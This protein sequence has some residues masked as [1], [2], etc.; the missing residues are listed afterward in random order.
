[1]RPLTNV[2]PPKCSLIRQWIFE[3]SA[4]KEDTLSGSGGNQMQLYA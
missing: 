2:N 3:L 1:M 4:T